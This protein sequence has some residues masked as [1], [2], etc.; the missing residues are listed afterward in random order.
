MLKL[1]CVY[2]SIKGGL[3]MFKKLLKKSLV[4]ATLTF[5]AVCSI[6]F[7]DVHAATIS[8]NDTWNYM[9][10]YSGRF[11]YTFSVYVSYSEDYNYGSETIGF[12]T[13]RS[14]I[15]ITNGKYLPFGYF[16]AMPSTGYYANNAL[17]SSAT[18][19]VANSE[20]IMIPEEDTYAWRKSTELN[21]LSVSASNKYVEHTGGVLLKNCSPSNFAPKLK[22]TF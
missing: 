2:G 21:F 14:Y 7:P 3:Q 12:Y 1:G 6:D 8:D 9:T 5:S 18:K 15:S 16:T 22:F 10:L 11:P 17:Q 4:L 20:S 19:W 13:K